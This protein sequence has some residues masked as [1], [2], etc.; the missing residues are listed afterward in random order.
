MKIK[1]LKLYLNY[2]EDS[3]FYTAI[4]LLIDSWKSKR[5]FIKCKFSFTCCTSCVSVAFS[6]LRC[7]FF[8]YQKLQ[9]AAVYW[10]WREVFCSNRSH[11]VPHRTVMANVF[12]KP[13]LSGQW[14]SNPAVLVPCSPLCLQLHRSIWAV[15]QQ[16]LWEASN[17]PDTQTPILQ[18]QEFPV[19]PDRCVKLN[20]VCC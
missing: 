19:F 6:P 14:T 10:K 16:M 11:L 17:R 7:F 4:V 13:D 18:S 1:D 12:I 9:S 2:P 3:R 5:N 20:P 8:S 15:I